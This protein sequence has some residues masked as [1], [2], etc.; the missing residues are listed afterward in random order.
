M[1]NFNK[2]SLNAAV[3]KYDDLHKAGKPEAD[4]KDAISKDEK[5]F[6]TE[7]IDSIYNAIVNPE[8]ENTGKKSYIAAEQFRDKNTKKFYAKGDAVKYEGDRLKE[9]MSAGVVKE[10]K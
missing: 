1:E 3:K 5:K 8:A 4:V 10:S 2:S 9:L 6:T 7:Q